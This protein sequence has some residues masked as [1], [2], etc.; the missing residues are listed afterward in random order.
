MKYCE[1]L[2]EALQI[3]K[4]QNLTADQLYYRL[5]EVMN[6]CAN[7]CFP[8]RRFRGHL[9]PFWTGALTALHS[10]MAESR[11][12]GNELE[13][14]EETQH[15]AY[16]QYKEDTANF[17]RV[18]RQCADRY[19]AELD[20]KLEHDMVHDTVSFWK[21]VNS[22]KHGSGAN[23]GGGIQ[24]NGTTYR[25]R[26]DIVDQWAKYFTD[27]Y[28]QSNL[29]DFDAEWEHYVK[30]EV[31]KTFLGLSPDQDVTGGQVY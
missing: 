30:Q 4:V 3:D 20:N 29:H 12:V 26:E 6:T 31:D 16:R 28:T 14:P 21:T 2:D 19:M 17:R 9:K 24:F 15:S 22:R 7:D 5:C 11:D 10:Q 8:T 23:L 18:M 13:D 25:S 27:L 1:S